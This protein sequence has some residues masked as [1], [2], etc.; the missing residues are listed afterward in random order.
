M[1]KK[2]AAAKLW[3]RSIILLI[4]IIV[5]GFGVVAVRLLYLQTY[6]SEELQQKAVEQQLADTTLSAKRGSIYDRN[7]NILAQSVTV[8]NIVIAPANLETD[9]ERQIVAKG[10]SEILEY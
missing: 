4:I 1:A 8:W 6:M 3:H 2:G 10:L 5:L 7:G 9:K